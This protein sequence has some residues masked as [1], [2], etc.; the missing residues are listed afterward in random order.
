MTTGAVPPLNGDLTV[1]TS[2]TFQAGGAVWTY[3]RTVDSE[4][5]ECAGP[6]NTS[7]HIQVRDTLLRRDGGMCYYWGPY[8]T[9][10]TRLFCLQNCS[11]SLR[12]LILLDIAYSVVTA[13]CMPFNVIELYVL[14]EYYSTYVQAQA[15]AQLWLQTRKCMHGI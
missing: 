7:V 1:V 6:L 2:A 15:L 10:A 4:T 9:M 14:Y 11:P 12:P 8:S 3:T 5:L 13:V